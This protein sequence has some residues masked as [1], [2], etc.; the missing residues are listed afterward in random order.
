M[1]SFARFAASIAIALTL[2][3][4][5]AAPEDAPA[6]A[7]PAAA[8]TGE[9]AAARALQSLDPQQLTNGDVTSPSGPTQLSC[10]QNGIEVICT[11]QYTISCPS[12][13]SACVPPP[14]TK[15]CC[16]RRSS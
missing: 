2:S 8:L 3:A 6:V 11:S 4:C 1:K 5:G 13:W 12:G 7:G 10:T 14:G 16:K 15:T 9:A